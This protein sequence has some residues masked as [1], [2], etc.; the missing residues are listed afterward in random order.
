LSGWAIAVS[1]RSTKTEKNRLR[2][3]AVSWYD[4]HSVDGWG[5]AADTHDSKC[6]CTTAGLLISKSAK[7]VV[8]AQTVSWSDG[9]LGDRLV[10]PWK[11]VV[12]IVELGR[13]EEWGL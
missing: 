10:I 6:P 2:V 13:A 4:A 1:K 12:K 5:E 3:V 9:M 11:M 8:I 7:Q